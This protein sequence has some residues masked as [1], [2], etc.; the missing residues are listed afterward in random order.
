MT[1]D[2]VIIQR[3]VFISSA[4]PPFAG[5]QNGGWEAGHVTEGGEVANCCRNAKKSRD[6]QI[7]KPGERSAENVVL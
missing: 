7:T 6:K 2:A 3:E 1:F 4:T 5:S